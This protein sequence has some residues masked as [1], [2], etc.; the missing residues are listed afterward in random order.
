MKVDGIEQIVN[1]KEGVLMINSIEQNNDE[2][3]FEISCKMINGKTRPSRGFNKYLYIN[4]LIFY[5]LNKFLFFFN[6]IIV[7]KQKLE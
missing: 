4:I 2:P 1:F 6:F 5:F 3:G 7:L